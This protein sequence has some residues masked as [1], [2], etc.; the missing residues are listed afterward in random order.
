MQDET[1]DW[2][3]LRALAMSVLRGDDAAWRKFW[4]GLTPAMDEWARSPRFLGRIT[5]DEDVRQDI[6]LSVWEKL[7]QS[8]YR[9]LRAYFQRY[10]GDSDGRDNER[11]RSWLW[12]VC[13]N[14]GIDHMR[15]VPEFVRNRRLRPGQDRALPARSSSHAP[16]KSSA[17]MYWHVFETL[18]SEAL[19]GRDPVTAET[20]VHRMLEF[21]D[22]VIPARQTLAVQL[23]DEEGLPPDEIARR[24]GLPSAGAAERAVAR[25]RDRLRY[26]PALELWCQGYTDA[27]IADELGWEDPKHAHRIVNSAKELLKRHFR[28]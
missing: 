21:V 1:I 8:D 4:L 24:L 20:L 22:Q 14:I 6:V 26:R 28:P 27:E 12:R 5:Q 17:E 16:Q 19:V 7:Q 23:A 13:K 9:K 15:K 3:E 11:F 10:G 18:H 25:S 2:D